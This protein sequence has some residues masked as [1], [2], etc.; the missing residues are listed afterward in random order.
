MTKNIKIAYNYMFLEFLGKN[1]KIDFHII[2][3]HMF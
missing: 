1:I 3:Y 2:I